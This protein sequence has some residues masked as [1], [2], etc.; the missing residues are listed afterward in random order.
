MRIL[1]FIVILGSSL[2]S[3]SQP[4]KIVFDTIN[5]FSELNNSQ[6]YKRTDFSTIDTIDLWN[7][8]ID[9]TFHGELAD[10][11][12]PIGRIFFFRAKPVIDTYRK[13]TYAYGW[14]PYLSFRIYYR[15]D[16]VFCY[17]NSRFIRLIASC[18]P[19]E[20]GG[21]IIMAGNLILVNNSV[22]TNCLR[23]DLLVDYCRPVINK[24]LAGISFDQVVTIGDLTK[25]LSIKRSRWAKP[26][27]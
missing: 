17:K 19:P 27:D 2:I 20:T 16:S 21:D 10:S 5:H 23:M 6:F 13:N 3:Y 9:T 8:D 22:C 14:I 25:R 11:I 12:K 4:R 7:Y 18:V 24:I 26:Y 15:K 1:L